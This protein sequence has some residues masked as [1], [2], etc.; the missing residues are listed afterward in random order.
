MAPG[1]V[2]G[3]EAAAIN[4]HQFGP[5]EI[6]LA[7]KQIEVSKQWLKGVPVLL[8]EISDSFEIRIH[9]A[10]QPDQLQ[11]APRLG[12]QP[13]AGANPVEVAIEV[14]LEQIGRMIRRTPG[15]C[16]LRMG[17]TQ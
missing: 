11:I 17:E 2:E 7:A 8:A 15:S 1:V 10:Q 5:K 4:G 9:P 14:K 13:P 12:F 6:H 16:R 3:F